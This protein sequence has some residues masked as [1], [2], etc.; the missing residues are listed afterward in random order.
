[1][2]RSLIVGLVSGA[3]AVTAVAGIAGYKV[4]HHAPSYADVLNVQPI[5]EPIRIPHTVCQDQVLTREAPLRDTNRLAGTAIGA[6]LGGVLGNQIGG[7]AG[8]TLATVA[9]AAAGGY[10]GNRVQ[11]NMQQSDQQTYT[12]KRC[13]T[14]YEKLQKV[15]GYKVT[16][17]L[18]DQQGVVQMDH[19]PGPRIPVQNGQL[20]LTPPITANPV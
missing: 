6:V 7:G 11:N 15:T 8:R 1:M 12:R 13:R 3:V 19:A 14:E 17:K 18:G 20:V 10:A 5:V 16:Y 4:F 9:G 2:D